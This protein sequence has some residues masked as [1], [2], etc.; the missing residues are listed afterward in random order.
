MRH[1]WADAHPLLTTYYEN[2]WQIES[3]DDRYLFEMLV[4]EGMQAGLSWLTILKRREAM[5]SALDNFDYATIAE[6]DEDDFER[7]MNDEGMIRN[8][9]KVRSIMSNAQAFMKVRAQYG[10]FDS[11]IWHFT[12]GKPV[13]SCFEDEAEI[14][15]DNALS[16]QISKDLKKRGFKFVGPVIIYGYLGAIGIIQDKLK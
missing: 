2:E 8:R 11:Y 1:T 14:P 15:T 16:Q 13:V 12:D 6:Y 7:L 5:R 3:H 10:T 9:L 4:L